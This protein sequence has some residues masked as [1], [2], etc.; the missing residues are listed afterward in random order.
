MMGDAVPPRLSLAGAQDKIPVLV[1]GGVIKLHGRS[2]PPSYIL[3]FAVDGRDLVILNELFLNTLARLAGLECP[4][5]T[6]SE[7]AGHGYLLVERYDREGI[8]TTGLRRIH[9]E[10][11][12]RPWETRI[13]KYQVLSGARFA[14]CIATARHA[15]RPNAAS[16]LHLLR[17]QLFNVLVGNTDGH[18]KNIS[19]LQDDRGRWRDA[20]AYDLVGTLVLGCHPDLAFTIGEQANSQQLLPRDWQAF[21]RECRFSYA[22]VRREIRALA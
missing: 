16:V 22:L 13:D 3:K 9:Q 5:T 20:P 1:E 18:A 19:L 11:S 15:C 21:A 17:W 2:T 8:G 10:I 12:A 7:I 4:L 14:Q 6:A